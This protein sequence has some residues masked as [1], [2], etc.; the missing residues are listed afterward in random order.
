[1]FNNTK[2]V[3]WIIGIFALA[4]VIWLLRGYFSAPTKRKVIGKAEGGFEWTARALRKQSRL[5]TQA[6]S[7]A[8]VT[9]IS[10]RLRASPVR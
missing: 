2:S 7:Y 3:F 4:A 1:M 8:V 9:G 5:F 6:R 10:S